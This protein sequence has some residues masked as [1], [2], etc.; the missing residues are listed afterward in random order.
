VIRTRL[1]VAAHARTST[2]GVPYDKAS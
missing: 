1:S 2:S